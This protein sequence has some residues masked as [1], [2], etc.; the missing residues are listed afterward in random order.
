MQTSGKKI[1]ADFEKTSSTSGRFCFQILL[2]QIAYQCLESNLILQWKVIHFTN[3][4][5]QD[6]D[7]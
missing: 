4:F 3:R 5:S 2:K 6:N 1:G 7:F